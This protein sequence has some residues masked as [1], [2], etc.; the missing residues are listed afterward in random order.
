MK[1][2][3]TSWGVYFIFY[4]LYELDVAMK[5]NSWTLTWSF[6]VDFVSLLFNLF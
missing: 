1:Y 6:L 4:V 5:R 2:V 3:P